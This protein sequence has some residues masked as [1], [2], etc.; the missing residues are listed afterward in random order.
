MGHELAINHGRFFSGGMVMFFFSINKLHDITSADGAIAKQV[1]TR[2]AA[3][4]DVV[5][6][7]LEEVSTPYT[8]LYLRLRV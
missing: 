1:Q 3:L 5:N 4:S 6:R 8:G 7:T 2:S